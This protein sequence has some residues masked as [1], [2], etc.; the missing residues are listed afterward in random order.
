ML[1]YLMEKIA[2]ENVRIRKR[3]IIQLSRVRAK[4]IQSHAIFFLRE[5]IIICIILSNAERRFN[6]QKRFPVGYI[7]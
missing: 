7:H 2:F 1:L 5:L 4:Y 3:N 6:R